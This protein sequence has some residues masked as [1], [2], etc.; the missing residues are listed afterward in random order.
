[1]AFRLDPIP[2]PFH[3]AIIITVQIDKILVSVAGAIRSIISTELEGT[4][5]VKRTIADPVD[6]DLAIDTKKTLYRF[7]LSRERHGTKSRHR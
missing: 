1:M 2:T 3:R 5:R 6:I 7:G 4:V